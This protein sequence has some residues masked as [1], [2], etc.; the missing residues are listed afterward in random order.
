M[1]IHGWQ[2][3]LSSLHEGAD[4]KEPIGSETG[5]RMVLQHDPFALQVL[6][7]I[8]KKQGGRATARQRALLQRAKGGNTTRWSTKN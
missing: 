6:D 1:S 3:W 7:T 4:D 8:F 5:W 2:S